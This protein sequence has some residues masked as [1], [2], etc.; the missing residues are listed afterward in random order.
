MKKSNSLLPLTIL[1]ACTIYACSKPGNGGQGHTPTVTPPKVTPESPKKKE[2]PKTHKI[3]VVLPSPEIPGTTRDAI[4][5][6]SSPAM[7]FG[8][9][10]TG[11]NV[12]IDD[13]KEYTL[14]LVSDTP[15]EGDVTFTV[16]ELPNLDKLITPTYSGYGLLSLGNVD[17][18]A[19][20]VMPKGGRETDFKIG[21]K[22]VGSLITQNKD[23]NKKGFVIALELKS[24]D[25]NS[26]FDEKRNLIGIVAGVTIEEKGETKKEG[27][28]TPQPKTPEKKPES[29]KAPEK[30]PE[31]PKAPETKPEGP[32]APEKKPEGP[33]APEKKP[34][35]P[36]APEKKPEGPKA[37]EKK[38][39]GP[40]APEKKPE[41]PKAPEKKPEGPKTPE[42]K[43]E[44]PKTPEKKPEGPKTPEKKP[45]Q[46]K[47]PEAK[48]K[49]SPG[50]PGTPAPSPGRP[51]PI[52]PP[53][54]SPREQI[55]VSL[56]MPE[57]AQQL[58]Q[59]GHYDLFF[60]IKNGK[61][62]KR[63]YYVTMRLNKPVKKNTVIKIS[64]DTETLKGRLGRRLPFSAI[65]APGAVTF[66]PNGQTSATI[67][68]GLNIDDSPLLFNPYRIPELISMLKFSCYDS[69]VVFQDKQNTIGILL[70]YNNTEA[71]K[72]FFTVHY[73]SA[74]DRM[75][76]SLTRTEAFWEVYNPDVNNKNSQ[77]DGKDEK[78]KWKNNPGKMFDKSD[79]TYWWVDSG[80]KTYL[81]FDFHISQ[82]KWPAKIK[83]IHIKQQKALSSAKIEVSTDGRDWIDLGEVKSKGNGDETI[84]VEFNYPTTIK[85]LR[86]GSF[87]TKD[88]RGPFVDIRELAFYK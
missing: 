12:T 18:P 4:I 6:G 19:K 38:P 66:T 57:T 10:Q 88:W 80:S 64:E 24:S 37:P 65:D 48:P 2:D 9:R 54:V 33:K 46:P 27:D 15:V 44:G 34:E 82:V 79:G 22:D 32:K 78:G 41:G 31:S 62:T 72:D 39:E 16:S 83:G 28:T 77:R 25:K 56:S 58:L 26:Q 8:V 67:P 75:S 50:N 11:T 86:I 3:S 74:A 51:A 47:T 42:K 71:P 30:K 36:K 52:T 85:K 84:F 53:S 59:P 63:V 40:K 68:I 1:L 17:L 20:I 13:P 76:E 7:F 23:K 35:G 21:L 81:E 45:G 49:P 61:L 29:P 55:V 87:V 70:A 69:D 60:N 43:P 5:E 73:G 14:K